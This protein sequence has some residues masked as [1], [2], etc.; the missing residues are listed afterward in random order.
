MSGL[1]GHEEQESLELQSPWGHRQG[2]NTETH[3]WLSWERRVDTLTPQPPRFESSRNFG[4]LRQTISRDARLFPVRLH[5]LILSVIKMYNSLPLR[6]A[7]CMR[8]PEVPV[9]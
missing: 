4:K 7:D 8:M 6:A 1:A 3:A 9:S 2:V 5:P